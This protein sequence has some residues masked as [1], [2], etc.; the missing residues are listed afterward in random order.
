MIAAGEIEVHPA[1]K[2]WDK[3]WRMKW[4]QLAAL[5]LDIWSMEVIEEELGEDAAYVLPPLVRT[6]PLT[7]RLPRYLATMLECLEIRDGVSADRRIAE[8]LATYA[9]ENASSLEDEIPGFGEALD[10]PK[11]Q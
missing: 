9:E 2:A 10:F 8:A 6:V 7:I 3:S 1:E 5:A 11:V 4:P